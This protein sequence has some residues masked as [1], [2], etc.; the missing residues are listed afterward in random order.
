[1][2]ES[3]YYCSNCAPSCLSDTPT[4][5]EC[6]PAGAEGKASDSANCGS[7]TRHS[8]L[9]SSGQFSFDLPLLS[10]DSV[11]GIG[12]AFSL[13]YLSENAE[14][15]ILGNGF[16]FPQNLRLE[17]DAVDDVHLLTGDNTEEIFIEDTCYRPNCHRTF[18]RI[19]AVGI[20]G[21]AGVVLPNC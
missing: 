9:L 20:S 12:W 17:L 18:C 1:M 15:R 5:C 21:S 14:G 19:M 13:S 7:T 16:N 8:V 3:Y 11:G 10:I 6:P 2:T 4:R